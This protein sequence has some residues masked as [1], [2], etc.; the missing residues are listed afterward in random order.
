DVIEELEVEAIEY[1]LEWWVTAEIGEFELSSEERFTLFIAND[2]DEDTAI[3]VEF[4]LRSVYPNPFNATTSIEFGMDRTANVNIKLFDLAGRQAGE[5]LS[6]N[7]NPGVHRVTWDAGAMP[8][9]V[10]LLQI[11]SAGRLQTQKLVLVR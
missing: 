3:P 8:S 9:G 5:V 4:G 1:M 10:Y 6:A 7:M 2:V 11:E